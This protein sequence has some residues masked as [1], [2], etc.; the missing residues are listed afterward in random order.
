MLCE[1]QELPSISATLVLSLRLV[2]EDV[3]ATP[4]SRYRAPNIVLSGLLYKC[5]NHF[6][7]I[8]SFGG[9]GDGAVSLPKFLSFLG[10]EYGRGTSSESRGKAAGGAAG[11]RSLAG[12]LRLILK[13]VNST[14]HYFR[15]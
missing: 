11:G 13:K 3:P 7:V 14:L 15:A 4:K 5:N 10:K 2:S 1:P 12:R 8:S 9:D 6:Q